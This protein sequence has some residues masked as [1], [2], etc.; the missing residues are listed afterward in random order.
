MHETCIIPIC[1][2]RM[3]PASGCGVILECTS[4]PVSEHTI[5]TFAYVWMNGLHVGTVHVHVYIT[6]AGST[7]VSVGSEFTVWFVYFFWVDT[8]H[9]HVECYVRVYQKIT[10]TEV[11]P[12]VLN[13]R[14]VVLHEGVHGLVSLHVHT[15]MSVTAQLPQTHSAEH[16]HTKMGTIAC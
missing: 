1:R 16:K 7:S 14:D 8:V 12:A 10:H 6:L 13:I 11:V 9:V 4:F 3:I 15:N 5:Y 2:H